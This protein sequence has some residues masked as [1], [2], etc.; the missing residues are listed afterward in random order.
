MVAVLVD[1]CQPSSLPFVVYLRLI[2]IP[3]PPPPPPSIPPPPLAPSLPLRFCVAVLHL[4]LPWLFWGNDLSEAGDPSSVQCAEA[5]ANHGQ[6][7]GMLV[8]KTAD[9]CA[10][11]LQLLNNA[12]G[13]AYTKCKG[14]NSGIKDDVRCGVTVTGKVRGVGIHGPGPKGNNQCF[15][16]V[17]LPML[18]GV[19][20]SLGKATSAA[21]LFGVRSLRALLLL[22]SLPP[23][24][25]R[26]FQN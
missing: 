3:P 25:Q 24:S 15:T 1:W 12:G 26:R 2:D 8:W 20:A 10:A 4:L 18:N 7:D 9:D 16:N 5:R 14:L 19:A 6:F 21:P 11:A 23:S 13:G 17:Y 22:H